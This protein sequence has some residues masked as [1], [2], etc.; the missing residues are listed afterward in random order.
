MIELSIKRPLIVFVLFAIIA[1][2]GFVTFSMLNINLT[3]KFEANILTI[4]TIYP[5]ASATEVETSVT[6][7]IEDAVSS[8][9]NIKSISSVSQEGFEFTT[10]ELKSGA[11]VNIALQDA[12]RK[13]NAVMSDL[14]TDVKTPTINKI[15]SDEMPVI[16][17]AVSS[18]I[19]STDFYK[20][21][22]DRIQPRL[23]KLQGV[24][25]IN[26]IGGDEREIKVNIDQNKLKTYNISI[27]QILSAIKKANMDYPT[28]SV[29]E[30]TKKYTVRLSAK[31]VSLEQ[32]KN[33]AVTVNTDGSK[34][35]VK[36]VAEIVDGITEQT[37]ISR[38]NGNN[39]IGVQV[40]KQSDANSVAVCKIIKEELAGLEKE[41]ASNNLKFEIA[42]DTSV[43]TMDSVNA[44]V[45]DLVLAVFIVAIVCFIF[46]HSLRT[47][48]MVMVAVPL[49]MLPSF[50]FLYTFGYSLNVLSL[51]ALSLAVGILVDDA[52]VV[53]EN[54]SR[55]L[56]MGK[57]KMQAAL[58]GSKQIFYTA[59]SI[60]LVIVSVFLP[61]SL[62]GGII[63]N[64]LK[65]FSLPLIVSTLASLL[66][67][68]TLTPLLLSKFGKIDN[69][70]N[71]TIAGKFTNKFETIFNSVKQGYE[72]LLKW[73]LNNRKKVYISV[74][75][76]FIASYRYLVW[77]SSVRH[78]WQKQ[79]RENL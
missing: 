46:L 3:P 14:P 60:T 4:V 76:L 54:I 26:L 56:E 66:V 33:T 75:V 69:Y 51:M 71:A 64:M 5:G 31:Y 7:K 15:S 28:G 74:I 29:E 59:T 73:G 19:K 36:D 61:L 62:T 44:V 17:F 78:L 34:I 55:H 39:A 70:S 27:L 47:A 52:I 63:G 24:G 45:E 22:E 8:L 2:L 20:L 58:Q 68:F 48:I 6:K 43:Y 41:Y 32:I 35:F 79:T 13:V 57:T 53:V 1:L 50:I 77:V 12:Q 23:S 16:Q 37:K 10:I 40:Q 49:S 25:Q 67:S 11:D 9:E 18:D 21:V 38:L 72:S 42:S 65:E 30:E